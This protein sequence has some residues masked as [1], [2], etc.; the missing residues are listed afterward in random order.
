MKF[1]KSR[2]E[3]NLNQGFWFKNELLVTTSTLLISFLVIF[4]SVYEINIFDGFSTSDLL[5]LAFLLVVLFFFAAIIS[6][7]QVSRISVK[8]KE[9]TLQSNFLKAVSFIVIVILLSFFML[10]E[11]ANLVGSDLKYLSNDIDFI[12]RKFDFGNSRRDGKLIFKMITYTSL[13]YLGLTFL[14]LKRIERSV[15]R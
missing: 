7:T 10:T 2:I 14:N 15:S 8:S 5:A 13:V 1:D 3:K 4:P 9:A 12:G 6:L 11:Q